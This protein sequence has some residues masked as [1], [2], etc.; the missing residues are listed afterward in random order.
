MQFL[1]KKQNEV[2][3]KKQLIV[4]LRNKGLTFD[5]INDE[6]NEQL[7]EKGLKLVKTD[8]AKVVYNIMK[9]NGEI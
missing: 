4:E 8:Y 2:L 6:L 3:W 5:K 1:T 7:K 9:R